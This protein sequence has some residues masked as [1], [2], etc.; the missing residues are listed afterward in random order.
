MGLFGVLGVN[1]NE[2]RLV[3][4]CAKRDLILGDTYFKKNV[5][6]YT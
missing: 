4:M 6:K 3:Q 2:E 5:H 1:D